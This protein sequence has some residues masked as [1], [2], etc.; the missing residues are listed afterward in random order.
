MTDLLAFRLTDDEADHGDDSPARGASYLVIGR[1]QWLYWHMPDFHH[2]RVHVCRCDNGRLSVDAI[3]VQSRITDED[4]ECIAIEPSHVREL[5][6]GRLETAINSPS[7]REALHDHRRELPDLGP[8][9]TPPGLSDIEA[10]A[11]RLSF[12]GNLVLDIPT[13]YQKPTHFYEQV[14][15]AFEAA[16][17][18]SPHPAVDIA[19]ANG[20]LPTTTV[21]RWVREARRRKVMAPAP[22][23]G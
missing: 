13:T 21:H 4:G 18:V 16:S 6:L 15:R 11:R 14:A 1:S 5:R 7:V 17:Q 9:S 23:K 3:M 22:P 8:G 2:V 19:K 12:G 10:D 20:D